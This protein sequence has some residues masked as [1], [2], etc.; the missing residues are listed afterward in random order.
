M[1]NTKKTAFLSVFLVI[2]LL[3]AS[4]T[5]PSSDEG[6]NGSVISVPVGAAKVDGSYFASA[7][8]VD[9]LMIPS[10]VTDF[11]SIELAVKP[12]TL[13]K[14]EYSEGMRSLTASNVPQ[15]LKISNTFDGATF[16]YSEKVK[17][18]E[19]IIPKTVEEIS[20]GCFGGFEGLV[21]FTVDDA[22][23]AYTS[24]EGVLFTKDMKTLVA[25]PNGSD[26][27]S[28]TIP[29]G[30]EAIADI[31]F[32]GAKGLT[33][34]ELPS[35]LKA[36]GENA[37]AG[38]TGLSE[39][40]SA[41]AEAKIDKEKFVGSLWYSLQLKKEKGEFVTEKINGVNVLVKYNG[42]GG[43]V[44]LPDSIEAIDMNAFSDAEAKEIT[45][46]KAMVEKGNVYNL[47]VFLPT[48]EKYHL[49]ES[50][51]RFVEIDGVIYDGNAKSLVAVPSQM[52]GDLL[53]PEGYVKIENGAL[54][55]SQISSV[56]LPKTMVT[57]EQE[58]FAHM[59]NLQKI[60]VNN[61]DT[62]DYHF[63]NGFYRT[64]IS[65]K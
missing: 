50:S 44:V 47:S 58:N 15:E 53:I 63:M 37:F 56:T 18:S 52:K 6:N 22:N 54:I 24:V 36:I 5:V 43:H 11:A 39:I 46:S 8:K 33:K 35:T 1:K 30:V 61:P 3:L 45:F 10:T 9:K 23:G 62:S 48:A 25:Y 40:V 2:C 49:P 41:S 28:Y 42:E 21:K 57:I 51:D 65:T 19:I 27:A 38:C 14:L 34:L 26:A 55:D 4:C 32:C 7:Q 59:P 31:A 16:R 29:N 64:L 20:E 12:I 17:C 60:T 13:G